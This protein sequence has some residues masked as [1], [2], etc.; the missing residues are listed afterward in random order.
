MRFKC[1]Y[2]MIQT[3]WRC[4]CTASWWQL[5]ILLHH[6]DCVTMSG[7][8]FLKGVLLHLPKRNMS[9]A[10]FFLPVRL[11]RSHGPVEF[12]GSM[13]H[14][15]PGAPRER[16]TEAVP[17]PEEALGKESGI[18]ERN[19]LYDAFICRCIQYVCVY[20]SILY[21]IYL[22]VGRLRQA[23]HIIM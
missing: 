1:E 8:T 7:V 17:S 23:L 14:L 21:S 6:T 20:Y 5:L 12:S 15:A 2:C 13:F 22:F 18:K 3:H 4:H 10:A 19:H 9:S 11:F 16:S